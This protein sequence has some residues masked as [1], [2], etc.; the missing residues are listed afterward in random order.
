M[1]YAIVVTLAL[2][3]TGCGLEVLTTTAITGELQKRDAERALDT[4]EQTERRVGRW[5]VQEAVRAYR[6]EHERNPASLE[7]LV[8]E[9]LA[10]VP[11]NAQGE[12]MTYNP[13]TG[14]VFEREGD[15]QRMERLRQAIQ[16]YARE[17]RHY[18]PNLRA[19]TPEYLSEIPRTE[20]GEPFAYNPQTGAVIHPRQVRQQ[21]G[22]QRPG[23]MQQQPIYHQPG[24]GGN[25]G[26]YGR[27][28]IR[29]IEQDH[30]Q[31]QQQALDEL[32]F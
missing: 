18:P 28:S 6:A 24:A 17:R 32:G 23:G 19:L 15:G 13:A 11:K 30:N 27:Q 3:L 20:T 5:E 25:V 7:E 14:E 9:Y 21:Q 1:R 10:E 29:G 26:V 2:A 8:P 12:P 31:R 16:N 22:S 4:L